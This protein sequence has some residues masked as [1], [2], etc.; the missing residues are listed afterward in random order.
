MLADWLIVVSL[1]L[2]QHV[3]VAHYS[4]INTSRT[5][6][7]DIVMLLLIC[8]CLCRGRPHSRTSFFE[9]AFLML[10]SVVRTGLYLRNRKHVPCFYRV[11]Q[12][13]VEVWENEK[14]C[15]SI[16]LY[17]HDF[18]P[19]SARAFL[20]LF[21][22]MAYNQCMHLNGFLLRWLITIESMTNSGIQLQLSMT[23]LLRYGSSAFNLMAVI[24]S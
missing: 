17:K 9:N 18:Q 15:V 24:S 11:V 4:D 6:D 12:T 5:Q 10:P 21:S 16:E 7:V 19:I 3:F 2:C 1:C 20:G 23:S 13:R 8:L 14:C 22:K